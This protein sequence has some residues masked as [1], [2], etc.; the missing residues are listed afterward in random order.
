MQLLFVHKVNEEK[1]FIVQIAKLA[2]T[3]IKIFT[4]ILA[5]NFVLQVDSQTVKNLKRVNSAL[6]VG[7]KMKRG[8]EA[9]INA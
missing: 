2:S 4:V 3:K 5:A 6:V 9:A 1:R 7:T 8:A